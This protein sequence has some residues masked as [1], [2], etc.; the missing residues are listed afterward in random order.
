MLVQELL[1]HI[2][3]LDPA[4][5]YFFCPAKTTKQ[6]VSNYEPLLAQQAVTRLADRLIDPSLRDF[7]YSAFYADE[8]ETGEIVQ[9]ALTV[10]FLAERRVVVVHGAERYESES[11]GAAILEYIQAPCESTV[12][13]LVAS[14]VD[15]RLKLYKACEKA[16]AVVECPELTRPEAGAWA[17]SA[18][19]ERHKDIDS[20]ALESLI[21][22]TGTH[23]GEIK[24]A[25]ELVC[26]YVGSETR[27]RA[28]DVQ[29]ACADVTE[30][31][32]WTMTDAIA[33]SNTTTA[34]AALRSILDTGASE[35]E[36]MGTINWLLKSAWASGFGQGNVSPYVAKKTKP[37]ADKL[38]RA[39]LIQAFSL[40]MEA[41]IMLR[42]TGVNRALAL[43]MLV[44]KLAAPRKMPGRAAG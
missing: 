42:S 1:K 37:L 2:D 39:K 28:E 44:I 14:R 10:P 26:N 27:I 18:I 15:R 3:T 16:G 8:T 30:E 32:V 20:A 31:E 17:K 43:E 23:M 29:A 22:R 24:N 33:S 40:L 35:F 7:A 25:V 19:R 21:D 41:E 11:A 4:P 6:G 34:V 36:V 5:L 9:T 38:G 12:M 13:L